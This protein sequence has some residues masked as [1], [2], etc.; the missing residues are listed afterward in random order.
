MKKDK[1]DSCCDTESG[2][3]SSGKPL[4]TILAIVQIALLIIIVFQLSALT[5][6]IGSL[7]DGN[8]VAAPQPVAPQP[9]A[10]K[11]DMAKLVDDDPFLGP[12]DSKVVVI[13]FSD[14]QCPYCGAA[15]GTADALISRFKS[16]DPS[17]EPSV[18]KL[19]DLAQKG[20][21]KLVFRDFPLSFHP[22]ARP[23]AIAANCAAKQ[24]KFWEFHDALFKLQDNLG[25]SVYTQIA[26]EQKLDL[27]KW[28]ECRKD[29]AT[30]QEIAKDIAD[31]G[32]AG[33]QGTPAFFV[34]G[35]FISGAQPF[36]AFEGA[37][38]I[39]G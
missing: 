28:N 30:E 33:V 13:E 27:A 35:Q 9:S 21:L 19:K 39:S 15:M 38:G 5:K 14:F 31:G 36:K 11:I 8:T 6:N 29:P 25:E 10:P 7:A 16:Q 1:E 26:T 34:N 18:P 22:N 17:W 12:K 23:A 2:S 20:K 24:G 32:A 4:K 37:L 3:C